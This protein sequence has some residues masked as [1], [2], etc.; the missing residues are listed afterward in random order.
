MTAG[1][2]FGKGDEMISLTSASR[3]ARPRRPARLR[4]EEKAG[5]GIGVFLC[6][7]GGAISDK[8][9]VESIAAD[10]SRTPN[11]VVAVADFPCSARGRSEIGRL[12]KEKELGR[13]VVAGC[14]PKTHE[15]LFRET[16]IEAGINP[17]MFEIANIREQCAFV[18]SREAA[19]EKA[20]TLVQAAIEKCRLLAPAP[21]DRVRVAA[22]KVLILGDGFSAMR[23]AEAVA[24]E[25]I[26]VDLVTSEDQLDLG[27]HRMRHEGIEGESVSSMAAELASNPMINIHARS[28]V[29]Q[30]EGHAGDFRALVSTKEGEID[31]A[32]GAV[33]VALDATEIRSEVGPDVAGKVIDQSELETL[34]ES[35]SLP[36]RIVMI[37]PAESSCGRGCDI[38]AVENALVV[39]EASPETEV[40]IIGS[41]IRT[42]GLCELDYRKA[43]EYGI[44]FVRSEGQPVLESEE[45]LRVRVK[46]V[47][48]NEII[49]VPADLVVT[50]LPV[51]PT[52]TREI[53]GILKIPVDAQGYFRKSQVKL[54]PVASVREGVFLCGSAA[55]PRSPSEMILEAEAAGARAAAL[56]SSPYLE[57][58]G[59][60]AE[61]E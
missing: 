14:S 34:L 27:D 47:H 54:K 28:R 26:E 41:E 4:A 38:R 13:F 57:V 56:V 22:R 10:L 52:G 3:P 42:F 55:E 17:F 45:G 60:V 46:D 7:C 16:A 2:K 50:S 21:Y 23:A 61:V 18:H 43:Q 51:S 8:V 58:G 49:T 39:K 6:R 40:T 30:F 1:P 11:A 53:A 33:I 31:L 24:E 9:D 37:Q 25:G 44:R 35:A 5:E 29:V 20:K 19:T 15:S 32:A 59:A 36:K 48:A 12:L